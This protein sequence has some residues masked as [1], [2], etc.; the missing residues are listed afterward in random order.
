MNFN[1]EFIQMEII[2]DLD[3][4]RNFLYNELSGLLKYVQLVSKCLKSRHTNE[5]VPVRIQTSEDLSF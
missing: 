1:F 4:C 2:N 3:Q 5:T